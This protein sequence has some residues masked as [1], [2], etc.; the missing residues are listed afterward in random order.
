[1]LWMLACATPAEWPVASAP[2][3]LSVDPATFDGKRPKGGIDPETWAARDAAPAGDRYRAEAEAFFAAELG[4]E[5][6]EG[7]DRLQRYREAYVAAGRAW[8]LP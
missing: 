7:E 1:M 5:P 8:P 4:I 3:D 2:M 6:L